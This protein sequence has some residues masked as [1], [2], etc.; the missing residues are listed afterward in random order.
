M[1]GKTIAHLGFLAR[2]SGA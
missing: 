2:L 1:R